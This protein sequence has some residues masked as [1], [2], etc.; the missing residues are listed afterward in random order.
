MSGW[1]SSMLVL[2]LSFAALFS[3]LY[4]SEVIPN[5]PR[6]L[7]V[8]I[9]ER[10]AESTSENHNFEPSTIRVFIGLN[11]TV[12]WHN[13]DGTLYTVV[14]SSEDDPLFHNATRIQ[15]E[16]NDQN[17][18]LMIPGKNHLL[19]GGTFEFT[20][21]KPGVFDYHS[22]PHPNMHGTVVV[23]PANWLAIDTTPTLT[24]DEVA[25]I[26]RDDI[27]S[28][29]SPLHAD[30]F[31]LFPRYFGHPLTLV[32]VHENGTEY[33]MHSGDTCAVD[34]LCGMGKDLED[35]IKGHLAYI[36]DGDWQDTSVW[37]CNHFIYGV[38]ANT[39]KIL[40]A[41]LD[42]NG[43]CYVQPPDWYPQ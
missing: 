37:N 42:E 24:E 1:S 14:A 17:N 25:N 6:V 8:I 11:N 15:C 3:L 41:E 32:Y 18:C 10:T 33:Y 21:T 27:E 29:V 39:G 19:P 30:K 31:L 36:V 34:G 28:K 43:S 16:N 12:R 22:V 26:T 5:K 20:F 4:F 23:Y 40:F 7:T 9:P 13:Q 35:A 38:D 2:I